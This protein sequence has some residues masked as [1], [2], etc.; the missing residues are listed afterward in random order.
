ME[1][2]HRNIA[3]LLNSAEID[4]NIQSVESRKLLQKVVYLAQAL[5]LPVLYNFSWYVHGPY[6]PRLTKDYYELQSQLEMGESIAAD[7]LSSKYSG[8]AE[9]LTALFKA[10]PAETT[11]SDWAELLASISFLSLES[12]YDDKE[13]RG[14][15]ETKKPHVAH[16]YKE[17]RRL[18]K[19][20]NLVNKHK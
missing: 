17:A 18:L 5:G 4:F 13:T 20:D 19:A 7:K 14:L 12:G 10:K 9:K 2:G 15:L 1:K 6:S 3:A 16:L 11:P 8:I